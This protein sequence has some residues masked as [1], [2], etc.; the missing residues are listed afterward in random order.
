MLDEMPG[1]EW[2]DRDE[3]GIRPKP[4]QE[5]NERDEDEPVPGEVDPLD[6]ELT[7]DPLSARAGEVQ[8]V[9]LDHLGDVLRRC[10]VWLSA[11][12]PRS[13]VQRVA[14]SRSAYV[15]GRTVIA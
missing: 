10:A 11:R 9:D 3:P 2:R 7:H 13:R 1:R 4:R 8:H 5:H 12:K 15:A 14:T 6:V